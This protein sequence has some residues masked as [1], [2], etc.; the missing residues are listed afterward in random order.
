MG[1]A[2]NPTMIFN[3]SELITPHDD[4]SQLVVSFDE[5]EIDNVVRKMPSD[6]ALGPDG[7]N[8]HFL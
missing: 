4:L 5:T 6:K 7:F 3:L 8:N 1:V 2:T